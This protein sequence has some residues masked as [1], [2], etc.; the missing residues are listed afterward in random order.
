MWLVESDLS[1]LSVDME[2]TRGQVCQLIAANNNNDDHTHVAQLVD[3]EHQLDSL[4]IREAALG[5]RL[6][7]FAGQL[8]ALASA[9]SSLA[10]SLELKDNQLND[11]QLPLEA[12]ESLRAQL[13]SEDALA[14]GEVNASGDLL[15]DEL[16]LGN[17]NV[18]TASGRSALAQRLAHANSW[19]ADVLARVERRIA[20]AR[21]SLE[22]TALVDAL[23][24]S[25]HALDEWM[26]ETEAADTSVDATQL[27]DAISA[28]QSGHLTEA[29]RLLERIDTE[30]TGRLS[31]QL[32]ERTERLERLREPVLATQAQERAS[33]ELH[34][35]LARFVDEKRDELTALEADRSGM[36]E[37][38]KQQQAEHARLVAAIEERERDLQTLA[39]TQQQQQRVGELEAAWSELCERCEMRK[40][41]LFVCY[42]LAEQLDN[43]RAALRAQI[44][45]I[46]DRLNGH[47]SHTLTDSIDDDDD[48]QE[49]EED[50]SELAELRQHCELAH[51][52]ATRVSRMRSLAGELGQLGCSDQR[53]IDALVE[54]AAR[55]LTRVERA[56]SARIEA[57]ETRAG[58]LERVRLACHECMSA[59]EACERD[60][61]AISESSSSSST[62]PLTR[63]P[64]LIAA[65]ESFR[66]ERLRPLDAH[67]QAV[68]LQANTTS[69][70]RQQQQR[71]ER[72]REANSRLG[73]AVSERMARLEAALFDSATLDAELVRLEAELAR[74]G[75]QLLHRTS[76][77]QFD[78]CDDDGQD[79]SQAIRAENGECARLGGELSATVRQHDEFKELFERLM[80]QQHLDAL[81]AAATKSAKE[82]ADALESRVENMSHAARLVQR[83]LDERAA[84]LAFLATHLSALSDK[85]ALA[86]RFVRA[87][88]SPQ[89]VR[90]FALNSIEPMVLRAQCA[91]MS[92]LADTLDKR[93]AAII[94]PLRLNAQALLAIHDHFIDATTTTI[95]QRGQSI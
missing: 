3:M 65:H 8:E 12:Y 35:S 16:L 92:D 79:V 15:L 61:D 55:E 77:V 7:T 67:V 39:D 26:N 19:H 13:T 41:N 76:T 64:A 10:R 24:A 21:H 46:D 58:E 78:I 43:E 4:T 81:A 9:Y 87:D 72:V 88:L 30:N 90:D 91:R 94:T 56:L 51:E 31:E 40:E 5:R 6:R 17:D 37:R 52:R 84:S 28:K 66:D 57:L 60:L 85:Y 63:I 27:L 70:H 53:Q 75:D 49:E 48:N 83:Q 1:A 45:L 71:L 32:A 22:Q 62:L 80:Q 82:D 93:S 38:V 36:L 34:A 54:E 59:I 68:L 50:A 86:C 33:S 23:R 89:F 73:E 95:N 20:T 14:L 29:R 2:R 69:D 11:K 18:A 25:L 47:R 42:S 74:L 44:A